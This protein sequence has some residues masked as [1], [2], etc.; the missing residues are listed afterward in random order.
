MFAAGFVFGVVTGYALVAG[1]A[2]WW[3]LKDD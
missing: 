1:Y 3:L 2:L